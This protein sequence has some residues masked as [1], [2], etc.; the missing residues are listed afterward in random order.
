MHCAWKFAEIRRSF[1]E[2]RDYTI[3]IL[4]PFNYDGLL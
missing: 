1:S 2:K 3:E 4:Y